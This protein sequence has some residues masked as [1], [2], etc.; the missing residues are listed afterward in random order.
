MRELRRIFY[1]EREEA[2]F[3][4]C[5]RVRGNE[6]DRGTGELEGAA[7]REAEMEDERLRLCH[8]DKLQEHSSA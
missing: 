1:K 3:F 8:Y 4:L 2:A 5:P 6:T 7:T